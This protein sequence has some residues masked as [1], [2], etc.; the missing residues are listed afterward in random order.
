MLT[1]RT[2]RE[3]LASAE[4][5]EFL[6]WIFSDILRRAAI[7]TL[8]ETLP[9]TAYLLNLA[10][11]SDAATDEIRR[12]TKRAAFDML[13]TAIH[14]TV[15]ASSK[16]TVLA[17]LKKHKD[18]YLRALNAEQ[19]IQFVESSDPPAGF[20]EL[21]QFRPHWVSRTR[22]WR[23][24]GEPKQK[25]ADDLSERIA[26]AYSILI[27][28][29]CKGAARRIAKR[30]NLAG[31]QK[32]PRKSSNTSDHVE[33]SDEES[34]HVEWSEE[35]VSDRKKKFWRKISR[36]MGAREAKEYLMRLSQNSIKDFRRRRGGSTGP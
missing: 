34:D 19:V 29:K 18:A 28:S 9:V 11:G 26:V 4:C 35:A 25:M 16:G 15:R 17:Y 36:R 2:T 14:Q 32:R 6:G 12:L 1:A 8:E 33:W 24:F 5:D 10:G 20:D 21:P 30:L 7:L 23:G 31:I 27:D 3:S 13:S 22:V